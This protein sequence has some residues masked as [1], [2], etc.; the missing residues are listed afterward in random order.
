MRKSWADERARETYPFEREGNDDP[1]VLSTNH[2][3][4][5]GMWDHMSRKKRKKSTVYAVWS[6][7]KMW[8]YVQRNLVK[9]SVS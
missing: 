2:W 5:K 1:L 4:I 9:Y 3:G 8:K 7:W 6:I